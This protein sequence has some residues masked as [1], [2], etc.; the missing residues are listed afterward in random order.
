MTIKITY[1]RFS[2]ED[3]AALDRIAEDD[4]KTISAVVRS[5]VRPYIEMRE[6]GGKAA[7]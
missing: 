4:D 1:V 5:A 6:N 7:V 3:R 2:E